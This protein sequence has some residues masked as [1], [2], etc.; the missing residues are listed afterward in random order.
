MSHPDLPNGHPASQ[1]N[2]KSV[3]AQVDEGL[4]SLGQLLATPTALEHLN[5]AGVSPLQLIERH[6]LGDWGDINAT[7]ARENEYALEHPLRLLSAYVVGSEK[8]LI[9][10]EADRSHTTLLLISEY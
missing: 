8:I 3:T 4:F 1:P 2:A 7:D 10:T 6:A 5:R 9:I